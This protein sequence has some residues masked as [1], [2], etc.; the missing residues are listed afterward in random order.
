MAASVSDV[1]R[2]DREDLIADC[3]IENT[4]GDLA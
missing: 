3:G 4:V 1:E 2:P